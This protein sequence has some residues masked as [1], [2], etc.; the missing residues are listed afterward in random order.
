M[1]RHAPDPVAQRAVLMKCSVGRLC[2][3]GCDPDHRRT[4][5]R[6]ISSAIPIAVATKLRRVLDM[7][8]ESTC[9][10]R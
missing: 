5:I 9:V 6:M 3:G 4:V 2:S 8:K 7:E 10:P 1:E